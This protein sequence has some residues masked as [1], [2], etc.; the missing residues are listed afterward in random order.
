MHGS[1]YAIKGKEKAVFLDQILRRQEE[2]IKKI[3]P[4]KKPAAKKPVRVRPT[5]STLKVVPVYEPAVV[6]ID[7]SEAV[8]VAETEQVIELTQPERPAYTEPTDDELK[9]IERLDSGV[10]DLDEKS[11]PNIAFDLV[12]IFEKYVPKTK[13]AMAKVGAKMV[14]L[15]VPDD[16]HARMTKF[17][18]K[19][20]D[21][22]GAPKS[23]KDLG[24][25][26]LHYTLDDLDPAKDEV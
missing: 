20:K 1:C 10:F 25:M 5:Q 12:S 24:L 18:E 16:M 8:V 11:S 13:G 22:P 4:V 9:E 21:K 7:D 26:C 19:N 17:L 23:L 14:G 3:G 2:Y 15:P 6:E